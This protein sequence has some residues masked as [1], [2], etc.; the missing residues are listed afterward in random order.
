MK[1]VTVGGCINLPS[2]MEGV[3]ARTV[4]SGWFGLQ[5]VQPV[6]A[7][8]PYTCEM[9]ILPFLLSSNVI[10]SIT[11]S[12]VQVPLGCLSLSSLNL[13]QSSLFLSS[14]WHR[15][16]PLFMSPSVCQCSVSKSFFF[17]CGQLRSS[18][19]SGK[20]NLLIFSNYLGAKKMPKLKLMAQHT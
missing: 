20:L 13:I 4:E 12:T 1:C 8:A 18:V 6:Y 5:G 9:S 2:V 17:W 10:I 16:H 14:S 19:K 3:I 15:E 7:F 11:Y